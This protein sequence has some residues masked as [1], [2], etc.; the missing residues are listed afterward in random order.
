MRDISIHCAMLLLVWLGC[1]TLFS[2]CRDNSSVSIES[3]AQKR[4]EFSVIKQLPLKLD[5]SLPIAVVGGFIVADEVGNVRHFNHS[6]KPQWSVTHAG[7]D[8]TGGGTVENGCLFLGSTD[9]SVL[10]MDVDDGS[11]LWTNALEASF[12]YPPLYG[13]IDDKNA[14]WLL[15]SD[16]G[17]IFCLN[18]DNGKVLWKS[19]ETNR[20]DGGM[21]LW[22]Q[23]L[24]Y[25]NC[26][27]AAYIFNASNGSRIASIPV[28]ESDQMAGT[29][30]VNDE[31]MLY[32]GTRQGNLAV[33]DIDQAIL[34][35]TLKIS[36]QE[37]FAVPVLCG[38]GTVAFGVQEGDLLLLGSREGAL[39]VERKYALGSEIK[40]LLYDEEMLYVLANGAL[41]AFDK[42]LK[43]A[44]SL[45]VGDSF[46]GLGI[47]GS[48]FFAVKADNSLLFVKGEWK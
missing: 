44:S 34:C 26:D 7:M 17:I 39:F 4:L 24:V 42:N 30:V 18:A 43:L 36:E 46:S 2:G 32:I 21:V 28:G 48:G 31:G 40:Y 10:C 37:A 12:S 9:G 16:D 6:Y 23:R 47:V 1:V 38:E 25:G 3:P 41:M 29:P 8:F 15:S 35:S 11:T 14:L 19:E 27:G 13:G 5:T 45:N 20:S 22:N 33:V